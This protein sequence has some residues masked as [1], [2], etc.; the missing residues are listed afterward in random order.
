MTEKEQKENELSKNEVKELVKRIMGDLDLKG[1]KKRRLVK[2]IGEKVNYNIPI[3][4][5]K[6]K[7][8]LVGAK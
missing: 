4:K 1:G 5:V 6:V 7:R 3:W 2:L 8:A